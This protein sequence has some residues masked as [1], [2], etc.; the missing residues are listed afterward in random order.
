VR[1]GLYVPVGGKN[2]ARHKKCDENLNS[3]YETIQKIKLYKGENYSWK[4]GILFHCL[5][6]IAVKK[7]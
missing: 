4:Y 2:Y 1:E 6:F 7:N 5:F 3:F